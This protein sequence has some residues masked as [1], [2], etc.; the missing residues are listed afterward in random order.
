MQTTAIA[1]TS[2]PSNTHA[3]FRNHPGDF[4]RDP[5]HF[6]NNQDVAKLL[7]CNLIHCNQLG[8]ATQVVALVLQCNP[9]RT[10]APHIFR[11]AF[12]QLFDNEVEQHL[13]SGQW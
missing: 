10:D 7:E 9:Q 4:C 2:E 11:L 1:R 3:N 6:V 8:N 13:P 12:R 5:G